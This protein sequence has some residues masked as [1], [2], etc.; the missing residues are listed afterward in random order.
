MDALTMRG[1][2]VV[3][4]STKRFANVNAKGPFHEPVPAALPS[5]VDTFAKEKTG[6]GNAVTLS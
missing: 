5:P 1:G 4:T 3:A 6:T 2:G